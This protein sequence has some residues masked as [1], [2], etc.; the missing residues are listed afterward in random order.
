[1]TFSQNGKTKAF[2]E[3]KRSFLLTFQAGG[4]LLIIV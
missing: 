4:P 2:C 3:Q 1:M